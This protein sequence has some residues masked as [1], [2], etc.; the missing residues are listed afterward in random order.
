MAGNIIPA[1]AYY[2][3]STDRQE[4]SIPDQREAV[5]KLAKQRGYRIVREYKDEGISG[6]DT[7]RRT[8]FKQMLADATKLGDFQAVLC[9]DQDRFGRFDPLEAGYWIKPLR[10]AGVYLETV[11]QGRIDWEDFAGRIVYAVQQEGKHAFLRDMSRNVIR[12]QLARAKRGEWLGGRVPYGYRLNEHK[13]LTAGSLAEVETVRWLFTTYAVKDTSVMALAQELNDRNVPPPGRRYGGGPEK[14]WGPSAVRRILLRPVY[15]GR[16]VWNRNR[17]GRYH[18][19]RDG[20]YRR[21]ERRRNKRS[22]DRADWVVVE[23]IHEPLVDPALF[24]RVQQKLI[25]R[26]ERKTPAVGGG[27]YLFTGLL[28]CGHCGWPLHGFSDKRKAKGQDGRKVRR[29]VC[30]NYNLHGGGEKGCRCNIV[31]ERDVV[32]VLIR[33]I[34]QEFLKPANLAKLKAEIRR[35]EEAERLGR[36]APAASLDKQI[37]ELTRKIDQGTEKWLSAPPSLTA[38]LGDKLEQWRAERETLETKRREL[39]KPAASV[40]DLEDAVRRIAGGLKTLDGRADETDPALLREVLRG[41]VE[42]VILW[43]R[44]QPYGPNRTQSVLDRGE[45]HLRPELVCTNVSIDESLARSN[46]PAAFGRSAG[47]RLMTVRPLGRS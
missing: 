43:F 4:A 24:E 46:A 17:S 47:A 28:R 26:R 39:A 37:G 15:I 19:V 20:D 16:A 3:M 35:Q 2:R 29:Y 1:V 18:E 23:D 45:I 27:A 38:I 7:E 36:E 34:Q 5:E 31:N 8:G 13:R 30:G 41:F 22:T 10:D 33:T 21:A 9:W 44:H 14:L 25:D 12:G 32:T 40:G 42:R 11:G 6:D